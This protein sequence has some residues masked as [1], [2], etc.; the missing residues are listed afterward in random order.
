[1]IRTK[2]IVNSALRWRRFSRKAYAVFR[3]LGREVSIGVLG[4]AMLAS[5]AFV[6]QDNQEAALQRGDLLFCIEHPDGSDGL[7]EAI[8]A[9]TQGAQSLSISHVAI[10][11]GS[12]SDEGAAPF[13]EENEWLIESVPGRGVRLVTLT[14]FL[15]IQ[16]HDA[17]MSPLVVAG[18]LHDTAGVAASVERSFRYLGRPYDYLYEPSDSAIYCSELVQLSYLRSDGRAVF[19]TIGM[20]FRDAS[21]QIADYWQRLYAEHGR[22][23]PEGEPGTNP[24]AM[25]RDTALFLFHASFNN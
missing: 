23:V 11:V 24:G 4:V 2:A 17:S 25:S 13:S 7:G 19:P 15:N 8:T 1:M 5:C 3:S 6:G 10:Y 18:R 22:P 16:G 9:V 12:R 21:G 20:T 14:D